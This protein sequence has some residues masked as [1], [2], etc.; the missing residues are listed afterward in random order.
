VKLMKTQARGGTAQAAKTLSNADRDS[1]SSYLKDAERFI[2]EKNYERALDAL[3]MAHE[4]DP[5]NMYIQAYRERIFGLQAEQ[6]SNRSSAAIE[7]ILSETDATVEAYLKQADTFVNEDKL[8]E[9]MDVVTQAY[10]LDPTNLTIDSY[11]Q[12]ITDL[13]DSQKVSIEQEPINEELERYLEL[14]EDAI[15]QRDIAAATDALMQA[16]VIDPTNSR[17]IECEESIYSLQADIAGAEQRAEEEARQKAEEEA[18]RKAEEEERRIAEEEARRKAEEEARRK[19]EEEERRK[20]EEEAR[21]KAE[22]ERKRKEEE[23]RRKAEE[24]RKRKEEE[25][26]RKAEEEARRKAEEEERR[27]AEEEARRKAEEEARR[28]KEEET[29]RKAE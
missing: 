18:R 3:A 14:A 15:R 20:A 10:M 5:R 21:R 6:G 13:K 8:D 12:R 29:R 25:A 1:V 27:K 26:R 9:A 22:E 23:L 19:A 2:K 17:V 16:F 4:L 7:K 28:K 11:A 24:E